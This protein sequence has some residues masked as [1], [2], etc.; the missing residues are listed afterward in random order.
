MDITKEANELM[1]I[2]EAT[3]G[4]PGYGFSPN[5]QAK[6]EDIISKAK[7]EGASIAAAAIN[8]EVGMDLT[9]NGQYYLDRDARGLAPRD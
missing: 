1:R 6:L 4:L 2:A 8:R 5:F 9:T 7:V 3:T